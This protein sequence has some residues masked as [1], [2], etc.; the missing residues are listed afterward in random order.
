MDL[1]VRI[2]NFVDQSRRN[3]T[4]VEPLPAQVAALLLAARSAQA[5][6]LS[7]PSRTDTPTEACETS[8][9]SRPLRLAL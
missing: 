6:S 2:S 4:R 8:T 3:A 9:L 1:S 7:P 5:V